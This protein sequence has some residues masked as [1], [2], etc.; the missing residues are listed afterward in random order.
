MNNS[1]LIGKCNR[2]QRLINEYY[3]NKDVHAQPIEMAVSLKQEV[4]LF[5]RYVVVL[6]LW[7]IK[8]GLSVALTFNQ[9]QSNFEFIA[10]TS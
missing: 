3:Y 5:R 4:F 1:N 2:I 9:N 8:H 10:K 7:F 6:V